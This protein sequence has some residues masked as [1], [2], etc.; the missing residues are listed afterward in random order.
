MERIKR[1]LIRQGE[2]PEMA[3]ESCEMILEE[4]EAIVDGEGNFDSIGDMLMSDHC[5]DP[6][7]EFEVLTSLAS[8]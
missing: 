5:L 7:F 2:S 4:A 3:E 6:S 1:A 8:R